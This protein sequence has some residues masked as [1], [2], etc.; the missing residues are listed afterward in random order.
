MLDHLLHLDKQMLQ[1]KALWHRHLAFVIALQPM[2]QKCAQ[3]A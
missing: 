2:Q 3:E 1:E